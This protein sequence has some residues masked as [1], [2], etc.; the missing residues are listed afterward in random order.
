[1]ID[2]TLIKF[3]AVAAGVALLLWP[4]VPKAFE[5]LKGLVPERKEEDPSM[6][7]ATR[8]L[9]V[10]R[11]Y[12]YDYNDPDKVDKAIAVLQSAIVNRGVME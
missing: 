10:V 2:P 5:A 12:V 8:A 7:E 9:G 6:V 11:D 1:M 4:L 3:G